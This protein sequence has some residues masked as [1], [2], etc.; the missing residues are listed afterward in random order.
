MRYFTHLDVDTNSL[1]TIWA[2]VASLCKDNKSRLPL[3]RSLWLGA[4]GHL[5]RITTSPRI[6][7]GS[8]RRLN[9]KL[10]PS[11][12]VSLCYTV[13]VAVRSAIIPSSYLYYITK[14][15][16]CQSSPPRSLTGLSQSQVPGTYKA[17]LER[18]SVL[19]MTHLSFYSRS[20]SAWHLIRRK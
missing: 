8:T 1:G 3:H 9:L 15:G 20:G 18:E 12:Q 5:M 2:L 14:L 17:T 19:R 16:H 13:C 4:I 6:K 10:Q 7:A 11:G